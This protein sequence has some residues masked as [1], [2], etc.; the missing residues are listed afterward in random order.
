VPR[1]PGIWFRESARCYYTKVNGKQHRLSPKE[2]EAK[3]MLYRL[4]GREEKATPRC[5]MSVRKLCDTY[6]D[7]TRGEKSDDRHAV[8]VR[9]LQAFSDRFGRRRPD[10]L[11]VHEVEDWL[12]GTGLGQSTR[13]L[14]AGILKAVMNWAVARQHLSANP[15]RTLKKPKVRRRER[16]LST[17]ER[18]L[19][20]KSVSPRFREFLTVLEQTGCRPFSEAAKLTA[21]M[22]DW[23]K[24]RAVLRNHKT[25]GKGK[26]RVIYFPP[27]VLEVLR[28]LADEHPTGPLLRNRLGNAW[29]KDNVSHYLIRTAEL[30]GIPEFTAYAYRH[31]Y[32][33]DA[34]TKGVPVEVVAELTGNSPRIIHAHY[35]HIDRRADALR[36]AAVRA[37]S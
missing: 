33:T 5:R 11:K 10:D 32:I 13:G 24:G 28:G 37:V 34:L 6:L 3:R 36:D 4:V 1:V 9:H 7:R 14:V 19:I 17:E 16:V 35:S 25:A 22:L 12:S 31:T 2:S 27:A 23:E 20:L 21:A 15:L 18:G 29:R 8:Q 30:L 26:P